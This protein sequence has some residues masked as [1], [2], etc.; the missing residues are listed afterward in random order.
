MQE[1][2]E[3]FY[4][5]PKMLMMA[6]AYVS[7]KTGEIVRLTDA[8]KNVYVV[9]KARNEFFDNH[10]DKQSD[11]AEMC[12]LTV[13]KAGGAIREFTKHGIIE[14]SKVYSGGEHKN[15]K[16]TKIHCLEL[17]RA[18]GDGDKRKHIP[19]GVLPE[20]IWQKVEKKVVVPKTVQQKSIYT[21]PAPN[22]DDEEGLPF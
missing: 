11:I 18:E 20:T 12:N 21:P 1:I 15:L 19:I 16:Y 4:K 17:L 2:D 14:S 13:R 6:D 9:M 8:D 3:Q 10:Y 7:R 5:F 22:W